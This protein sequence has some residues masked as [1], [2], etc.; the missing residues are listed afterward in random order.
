MNVQSPENTIRKH[1]DAGERLLW[2]GQPRQGF[3]FT[4]TDLFLVPF[5]LL[6][7]GGVLFWMY[8]A[9]TQLHSAGSKGLPFIVLGA[10]FSIVGLY[11]IV[12][13]FLFDRYH[14]AHLAYG[15]T[16]QRAITVSEAMPKSVTS[17]EVDTLRSVRLVERANSRGTVHLTDA[18]GS[19]FGVNGMNGWHA[20][21]GQ[22]STF[23]EI[24]R[25]KEVMQVLRKQ[26][27]RR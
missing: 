3:V 13:R 18:S 26:R 16:D 7:G 1:L 14:R 20:S 15:V 11:L 6:W 22:P 5:S 23:F 9:I 17:F 24:E 4:S 12:G 2:S 10:V 21:V 8:S 27:D 19:I 25:P